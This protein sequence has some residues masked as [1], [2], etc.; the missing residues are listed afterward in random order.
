MLGS[1]AKGM[2]LTKGVHAMQSSLPRDL[3]V[4]IEPDPA[5]RTVVRRI[6]EGFG[7]QVIE[8]AHLHEGLNAIQAHRSSLVAVL[9]DLPRNE[10]ALNYGLQALQAASLGV[11][12][13]LTSA[14]C[15]LP[16]GADPR[17][18]HK[19]SFLAKPYAR[20]DLI[21]ALRVGLS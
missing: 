5:V 16:V 9:F 14:G 10:T 19:V 15:T 7:Y 11:P 2:W 8:A 21:A 4:L 1:L 18:T 17:N 13:V 20:H 12:L 6:V 3:V